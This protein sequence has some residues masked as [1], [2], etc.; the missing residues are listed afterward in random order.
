MREEIEPLL[1]NN[2]GFNQST[3]TLVNQNDPLLQIIK[4]VSEGKVEYPKTCLLYWWRDYTREACGSKKNR[5]LPVVRRQ[6]WFC[7]QRLDRF[8]YCSKGWARVSDLFINK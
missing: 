7:K 8:E 3:C 1:K 2:F 5:S 4:A 6:N